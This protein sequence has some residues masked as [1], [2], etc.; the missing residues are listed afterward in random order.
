MNGT[1]D[2]APIKKNPAGLN[3]LQLKTLT[4]LQEVARLGNTPAPGDDGAFVVTGLPH[5]HGNHFHLGDA[6]V[7]SR[8]ATGLNNPAVWTVLERKGMIARSE[9][10][11]VVTAAGM[12]YDT[13]LRDDILHRSD[14]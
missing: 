8:D 11:P 7:S 1:A 2:M 13:G 3:P 12:A 6:V 9:G 10:G 14:H 4:L 5:A